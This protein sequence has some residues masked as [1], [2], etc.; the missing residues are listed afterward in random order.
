[1]VA[2]CER[3]QVERDFVGQRRWDRDSTTAGLRRSPH[4]LIADLAHTLDHV[5]ASFDQPSRGTFSAA[6]SPHLRA[7]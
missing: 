5:E 4:E 1:M 7:A 2:T 3:R 6:I